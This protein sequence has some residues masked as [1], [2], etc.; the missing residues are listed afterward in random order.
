MGLFIRKQ[1]FKQVIEISSLEGVTDGENDVWERQLPA[2]IEFVSSYV[3]HRYDVDRVFRTLEK[4]DDSTEYK[5]YDRVFV[6]SKI[7]NA[8]EDVPAGTLLTDLDFWEQKDNR[9]AAIVNTVIVVL[10]YNIYPRINGSEQPNW[11]QILYDGGDPR[12]MAGKIGWLKEIRKGTVD[13]D[14]PLLPD[15]ETGEDQSGNRIAYGVASGSINR[16]SAI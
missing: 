3:R 11:L 5:Q 12:Q 1:D 14:L 6:G 2:T 7:Y 4:H 15:V 9:N 16:N 13:V 10:L 8:L